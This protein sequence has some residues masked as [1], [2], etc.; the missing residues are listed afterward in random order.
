MGKDVR[1]Q[2]TP[3]AEPFTIHRQSTLH[4]NKAVFDRSLVIQRSKSLDG[5]KEKKRKEDERI[6]MSKWRGVDIN[7][8]ENR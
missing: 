8:R 2:V 1:K 6:R 4:D 7:V 3:A 5:E